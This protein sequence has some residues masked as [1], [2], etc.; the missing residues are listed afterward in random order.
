MDSKIQGKTLPFFEV[1]GKV[2]G[3]SG[4]ILEEFWG[5]FPLKH[6]ILRYI[7]LFSGS[8]THFPGILRYFTLYYSRLP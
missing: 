1:L 2:L 7:T 5:Y 6:A 4:G 8:I 3:E